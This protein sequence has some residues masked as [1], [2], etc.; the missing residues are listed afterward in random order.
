[1][2][3]FAKEIDGGYVHFKVYRSPLASKA[4][5][6][7]RDA[8]SGLA[9]GTVPFEKPMIEGAISQLVMGIA[10]EQATIRSAALQNYIL[11]AVRGLEPD[12]NEKLLAKIRSV[13]EDQIRQAMKDYL[14]PAL[15]S[16][17]SNVVVCCAPIMV[18]VSTLP[19]FLAPMTN[20]PS[21]ENRERAAGHGIQDPGQASRRLLRCL[22][23]R[24]RRG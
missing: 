24:G 2:V 23:P 13:T 19:A 4:I 12:F 11:G 9:D 21:T 22:R 8:I 16:G 3:H 10:D 14:L 7:A 18:E 15:T 6:A 20:H 1:M 17:T 5:A